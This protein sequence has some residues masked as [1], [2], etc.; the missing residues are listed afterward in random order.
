MTLHTTQRMSTAQAMYEHMGFE[1]LADRVFSDGFVL[2][3]YEKRI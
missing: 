2:L 3:T 1:R